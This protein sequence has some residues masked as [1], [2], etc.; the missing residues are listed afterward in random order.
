IL[1][2]KN[3]E[4]IAISYSKGHD[5]KV[6]YP[7]SLT[8]NTPRYTIITET[9]YSSDDQLGRVIYELYPS[10]IDLM[11]CAMIT[12]QIASTMRIIQKN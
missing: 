8:P 9:L 10:E 12:N 7:K 5:A 4:N 11:S 2:F 1:S 3:L 6:L